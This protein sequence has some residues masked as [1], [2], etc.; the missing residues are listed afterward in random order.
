MRTYIFILTALSVSPPVYAVTAAS[1][2]VKLGL[3]E[4]SVQHSMEGVEAPS[5]S[6]EDLAQIPE[7]QRAQIRGM[8]SGNLGSSKHC[9]TSENLASHRAFS[10]R[11]R[12]CAHTLVSETTAKAVVDFTC[13]GKDASHGT[14][15]INR[16]DDEHTRGTIKSISEASGETTLTF[17]S[18]FLATDCG[19]VE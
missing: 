7:A 16:V 4:T 6:E 13:T 15:T 19:S 18:K 11:N 1:L 2:G 3:W 8:M 9:I 17:Q 12:N 5:I 14:I 10:G